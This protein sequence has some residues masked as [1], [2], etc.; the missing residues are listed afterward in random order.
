VKIVLANTGNEPY[1]VE[2]G[3]RIAHQIMERIEKED[4]QQVAQFPDTKRGDQR[5]TRSSS[6]ID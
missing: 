3:D 4:Q 2:K 6:T 5:F 1:R